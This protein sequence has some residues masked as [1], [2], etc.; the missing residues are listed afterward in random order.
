MSILSGPGVV[1]GVL[2]VVFCNSFCLDLC[3]NVLFRQ[4]VKAVTAS[5]NLDG[6]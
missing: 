6:M 5:M 4:I 2:D 1:S 3:E